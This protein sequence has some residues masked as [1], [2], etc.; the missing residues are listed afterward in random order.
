LHEVSVE[1]T[2]AVDV[3]EEMPMSVNVVVKTNIR[4]DGKDY[5]SLDDVPED[6]RAAIAKAL[7]SIPS[8]VP[9]D[10]SGK[11]TLNAGTTPTEERPGGSIRL[12]FVLSKSTIVVALGVI[13][14]LA[15]IARF[16]L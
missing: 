14:I 15:L 11:F 13:L 2:F 16:M 4:V 6:K 7:A 10:V 5:A 3:R 1:P 9:I 12:E 8:T